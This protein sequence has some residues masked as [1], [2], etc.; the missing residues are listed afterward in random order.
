MTEKLL[1]FIWQLGYFNHA[2]LAS[3]EGEALSIL[4]PGTFNTNG[5]PDFTG[6][7]IKIGTTTFFGNVELHLQTSDWE[8]HSH[9]TDLQY[10]NVILH[11]VFRHDRKLPHAI[12]VLELEPRIPGLLLNRY[13]ELMVANRFIPCDSS[14]ATVPQLVWIAWKERLLSERLTRKAKLVSQLLEQN[15]HHWEE[16]FWWMLARNFG[17]KVNSEAF[18]A[19]AKS[20]PVTLLARHKASLHQIEALLFGQAGLLQPEFED[21]HPRMLQ[22]EYRFLQQKLSLLP[23]CMPLQFLRMRPGNFPTLRLAQLAVLVHQSVHLFATIRETEELA[24][25]KGLF[26]IAAGEFWHD[27]Y[28]FQH[29]S[30]FKIKTLGSDTVDNILIN[31]VIPVL[32]AFGRYHNDDRYT[33]KAL[34][35]LEEIPAEKNVII[36]GFVSLG[37]RSGSAYDTQ[38]LLELKNEYCAARKCLSCAVGNSILKRDVLVRPAAAGSALLKP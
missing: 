21:A 29:S 17:M 16:T 14:I 22:R 4:S 24:A 36:R 10:N 31:T 37:V 12:P 15:N 34:R 7:K 18:E 2:D 20:I 32:F 25:A 26:K 1:Q 35:W 30:P 13:H 6:A 19:I 8:K 28:S 33:A 3:V 23:V 5:G 27:H 38:A 11:V 9:G